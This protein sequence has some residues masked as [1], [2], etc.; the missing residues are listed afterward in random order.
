MADPAD[1]IHR[2]GTAYLAGIR[3]FLEG[4]AREAGIAD[5]DT[6]ARK[7]HILMKGSIVAAAEG[8]RDAAQRAREMGQAVLGQHG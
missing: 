3:N 8:D 4:L 2:A 6:F 5:A 7:W 1:P